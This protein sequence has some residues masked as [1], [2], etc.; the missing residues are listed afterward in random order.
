MGHRVGNGAIGGQAF[1]R[2]SR[3]EGSLSEARCQAPGASPL[4]V[5][6]CAGGPSRVTVL[7]R[8]R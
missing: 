7:S 3:F 2:L 1:G 5:G 6:T 8:M 4:P